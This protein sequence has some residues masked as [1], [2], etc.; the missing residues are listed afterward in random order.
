M[1]VLVVNCGKLCFVEL[2]LKPTAF[3]FHARLSIYSVFVRNNVKTKECEKFNA[4]NA[5]EVFLTKLLKFCP[6]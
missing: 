1:P 5:E 4:L 2:K 3:D 6:E